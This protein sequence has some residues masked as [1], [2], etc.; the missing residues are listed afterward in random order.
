MN[1][2]G[3]TL[4]SCQLYAIVLL[5]FIHSLL[6]SISNGQR[7]RAF[8]GVDF[9]SDPRF[10]GLLLL[11]S[12]AAIF[13]AAI[14]GGAL[15]RIKLKPLFKPSRLNASAFALWALV[16]VGAAYLAI[17]IF[18][19]PIDSLLSLLGLESA[20][21]ETLKTLPTDP[22]AAIFVVAGI[23]IGAPLAE[24]LLFRGAILH[25]LK[26]YGNGFAVIVS[27]LFFSLIHGN[28]VQS[29]MAF[30]FGLAL[31]IITLRTGSLRPAIYI[32]VIHNTNSVLMEYLLQPLGADLSTR[33]GLAFRVIVILLAIALAILNRNTIK[34]FLNVMAKKVITKKTSMDASSVVPASINTDTN[35]GLDS[36]GVDTAEGCQAIDTAEGCQ[37]IDT[38]VDVPVGLSADSG[39]PVPSEEDAAPYGP[40]R[41]FCFW[42]SWSMWLA[43]ILYI[44]ILA[45]SIKPI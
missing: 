23:C 15:T 32:H 45:S 8:E 7:W 30:V 42:T 25:V 9:L 28:F 3:V 20:V 36:A 35:V 27:A 10:A 17:F 39:S 12:S 24:E 6:S 22:L 5:I 21:P 13:L 26:P 31:G 29:P 34:T 38:N 40:R 44:I 37:T 41:W 18:S 43:L 19:Y 2:A 1:R 33:L 11:S 14:T 4:L 16:T